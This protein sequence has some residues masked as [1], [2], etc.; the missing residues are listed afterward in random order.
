MFIAEKIAEVIVSGTWQVRHHAGPD[1]AGFVE[2]RASMTD[3]E[4]ADW[5]ALDDAGWYDRVEA[6]FGVDLR[7][8][9]GE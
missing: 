1:V 3:E 6:A 5:G 7:P 8:G 4:W 2:W 9:S